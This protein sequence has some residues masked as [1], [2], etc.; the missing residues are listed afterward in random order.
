[1][2]DVAMRSR[3]LGSSILLG[4]RFKAL[5][6][7]TVKD[8]T[9]ELML[10]P[11]SGSNRGGCRPKIGLNHNCRDGES[12]K[13]FPLCNFLVQEQARHPTKD[14]TSGE[15]HMAEET[16]RFPVTSVENLDRWLI[17]RDRKRWLSLFTRS[18]FYECGSNWAFFWNYY[19]LNDEDHVE[20]I[21]QIY[22]KKI[23]ELGSH[24]DCK[25]WIEYKYAKIKFGDVIDYFTSSDGV[26]KVPAW[27]SLKF[28]VD[29]YLEE[30]PRFKFHPSRVRQFIEQNGIDRLQEME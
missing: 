2:G 9:T 18:N 1:M 21:R 11:D 12:C 24:W 4:S 6:L 27:T 26:L 8:K 15:L 22:D 19:Q 16:P 20:F 30:S 7:S 10:Q 29:E 17:E 13:A 5:P 3:K 14:S 28:A 25:T 23:G